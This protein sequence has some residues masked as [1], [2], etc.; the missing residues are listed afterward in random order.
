MIYDKYRG[1][2]T[3]PQ[4]VNNPKDLNPPVQGSTNCPK[5]LQHTQNSMCKKGDMMKVPYWEPT[6][7]LSL[8]TRVI[9]LL[10][11]C[12]PAQVHKTQ[13]YSIKINWHAKT[14]Y[15][16]EKTLRKKVVLISKV[17]NLCCKIYATSHASDIKSQVS[18]L[19]QKN[20]SSPSIWIKTQ[21]LN[22][23]LEGFVC[24]KIFLN[25]LPMHCS[26]NH[27]MFYNFGSFSVNYKL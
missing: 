7:V 19:H 27:V 17:G 9:R 3:G 14:N 5:T 6:T 8:V 26:C 20:L 16:Y 15:I 4:Y 22:P 12:T 2:N 1:K 10:D 11:L 25:Y 24:D 18:R 13:L 23:G 21:K